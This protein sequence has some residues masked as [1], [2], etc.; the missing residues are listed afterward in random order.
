VRDLVSNLWAA[1]ILLLGRLVGIIGGQKVRSAMPPQKIVYLSNAVNL[2]VIG[3]ITAVIDLSRGHKA[4]G[5]LTLD[6]S[7]RAILISSICLAVVCTAVIAVVIV[8]RTWLHRPPKQAVLA[9]LPR[10][11][12]ERLHSSFF[13]FDCPRRR[14]YLPRFCNHRGS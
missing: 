6:H 8:V 3:S 13:A 10:S 2:L 14:V 11:L 5:L 12:A 4:F 9:L 1:L 7:A